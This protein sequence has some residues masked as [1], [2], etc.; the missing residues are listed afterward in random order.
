[1]SLVG[2]AAS[3]ITIL[4][5]FFAKLP[6][7]FWGASAIPPYQDLKTVSGTLE[8]PYIIPG[9]RRM[10]SWAIGMLA[11][12]DGALFQFSCLPTRESLSCIYPREYDET[13]R[14]GQHVSIKYFVTPRWLYPS[15]VYK[16]RSLE[17]EA[18]VQAPIVAA[19]IVMEVTTD[20]NGAEKPI[21]TYGQS[22]ARLEAL[23]RDPAG[24]GRL[25]MFFGIV[26]LIFFLPPALCRI[27]TRV[28]DPKDSL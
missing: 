18:S 15:Y 3:F 6:D 16:V 19:A 24:I 25:R 8:A 11:T 17:G 12:D 26:I 1:M 27:A 4:V 21:L 14:N 22:V 23:T 10:S 5:V 13:D 7:D 9:Q 28:S 20:Q 2:V